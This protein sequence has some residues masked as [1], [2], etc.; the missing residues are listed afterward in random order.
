MDNIEAKI[1][2]H[3]LAEHNQNVALTIAAMVLSQP[4][5]RLLL[6]SAMLHNLPI[7][8]LVWHVPSEGGLNVVYLPRED[9]TPY[10]DLAELTISA[11]AHAG[12]GFHVKPELMAE[13][14]AVNNARRGAILGEFV[15][16]SIEWHY[17][18][19]MRVKRV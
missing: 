2:E 7:G 16:D 19:S 3:D 11:L 18:P 5:K 9:A 15:G 13:A 10:E 4:M 17:D 1:V 6:P 8:V 12:K 14:L